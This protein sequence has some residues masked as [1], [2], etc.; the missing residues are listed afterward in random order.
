V[1][2]KRYINLSLTKAS[3]IGE[4][5]NTGFGALQSF[6]STQ[7]FNYVDKVWKGADT[8]SCFKKMIT[9]SHKLANDS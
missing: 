7:L 5:V 9:I 8:K 2:R 3:I 6:A 4:V 1:N